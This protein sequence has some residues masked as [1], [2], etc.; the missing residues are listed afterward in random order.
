MNRRD[1]LKAI[2]AVTISHLVWN[3]KEAGAAVEIDPHRKVIFFVNENVIPAYMV[4]NALKDFH[5]EVV[6]CPVR[7]P[8]GQ[9][10]DDVIRINPLVKGKAIRPADIEGGLNSCPENAADGWSGYEDP[11]HH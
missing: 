6:I 4:A 2:P 9:K 5:V 8:E 10:I 1:L 3:G 7:I 11:S